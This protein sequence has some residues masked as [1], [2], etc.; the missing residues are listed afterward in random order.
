[1]AHAR[2]ESWICS[3]GQKVATR[4]ERRGSTRK[5]RCGHQEI[6]VDPFSGDGK[7]E[8]L[9]DVWDKRI[10]W[11][12]TTYRIAYTIDEEQRYIRILMIGPRGKFY[13]ELNGYR[14]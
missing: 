11:V 6:A 10:N 14:L 4:P 3:Q 8:D 5:N 12:G 1:M 13:E 7:C 9:K 2:L